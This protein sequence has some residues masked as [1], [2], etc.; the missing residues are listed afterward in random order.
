MA[1]NPRF[2]ALLQQALRE[3][4]IAGYVSE[5]QLQEWLGRLRAALERELP[6]DVELRKALADSLTSIFTRDVDRGGI[7]KRVPELMRYTIDQ[8]RPQLR[9]ELDRRIFAGVDLIKLNRT[10]AVEKTLQRFSGWVTSL[11]PSGG[12]AEDLRSLAAQIAKPARQVKFEARRV[13]VDQGHKL[14]AAVAHVVAKQEGA[15]AAIWHDRGEYDRGY[16]A[17]PAHLA[18]S[19]KIFLIRDSWAMENGLIRRG[20]VPYTDEFEQVAE[21]PLCSCYYEYITT[22][23]CLPETMLTSAGRAW[24]AG[25]ARPGPPLQR[26]AYRS[27]PKR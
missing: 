4:A 7:A 20:A 10:A 6:G 13:A 2:Y 22:P 24:V 9:A 27:R 15:I 12:S 1:V 5:R 11:P 16:D 21:L 25:N 19:G 17:R 3:F 18:R 26:A 8:V 14:G 23:H